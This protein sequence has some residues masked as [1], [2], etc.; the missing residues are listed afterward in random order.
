M[1]CNHSVQV[2]SMYFIIKWTI[3]TCYQD[4]L[5]VISSKVWGEFDGVT[6]NLDI[7][8]VSPSII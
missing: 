3:D 7:Q 8:N 1:Q 4:M 5:F 6:L 2:K